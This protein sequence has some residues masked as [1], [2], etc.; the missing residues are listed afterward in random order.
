MMIW[1]VSPPTMANYEDALIAYRRG[2][3][4]SVF[5]EW[6]SLAVKGYAK[7]QHHLAGMYARGEGV[8]QDAIE[9]ARWYRRAAL[10]GNADSQYRLAQCYFLGTGLKQNL[11]EAAEW[12]KVAAKSGHSESQYFLGVLYLTGRGVAA[13]NA[14]AY[15]WFSRAAARGHQQANEIGGTIE[16]RIPAGD[17]Y[18][19]KMLLT[20]KNERSNHGCFT[21]A[22]CN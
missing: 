12:S 20:E 7:A 5:R 16:K 2:N 13:N 14:E 3:V 21:S 10:R 22:N 18:R 4:V 17:I 1:P 9:A 11:G 8:Q 19:G 15:F 6:R